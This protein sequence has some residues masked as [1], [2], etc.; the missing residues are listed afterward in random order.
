MAYYTL[1]PSP[2]SGQGHWDLVRS[3]EL[4]GRTM[5][6]LLFNWALAAVVDRYVQRQRLSEL[7]AL[8]DRSFKDL[9]LHRSEALSVVCGDRSSAEERR[10]VAA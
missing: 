4:V 6:S 2:G 1:R 9:G 3:Q 8:S 5:L 10:H 7:R